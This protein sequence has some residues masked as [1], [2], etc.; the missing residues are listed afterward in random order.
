MYSNLPDELCNDARADAAGHA[1]MGLWAM[2]DSWS[3]LALTN[4]FIP[5]AKAVK[6]GSRAEIRALVSNGLWIEGDGTADNGPENDGRPGYHSEGYRDR[7]RADHMAARI[8]KAETTAVR[9]AAGS[10]GGKT[11]A[12]NRRALE[13]QNEEQTDQHPSQQDNT[14]ATSRA[15]PP[16]TRDQRPPVST[17]S[18]HHHHQTPDNGGPPQLTDLSDPRLRAVVV[19][20]AKVCYAKQSSEV[21]NTLG[22]KT[23][24]ENRLYRDHGATWLTAI[25]TDPDIDPAHLIAQD[26]QMPLE[27]IRAV[28]RRINRDDPP[29]DDPPADDQKVP[30]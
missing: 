29:A 16:E 27:E 17:S 21:R 9:R 25:N 12:E 28:I 19:L 4:G 3:G 14:F 24:V 26:T 8:K 2:C 5:K 30:A 22:W 11:A 13:Q 10:K 20:A 6:E 23:S 15:V 1:A 7:N 18:D